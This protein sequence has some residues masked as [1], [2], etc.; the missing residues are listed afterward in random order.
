METKIKGRPL[1]STFGDNSESNTSLIMESNTPLIKFELQ[2]Q[3]E[4]IG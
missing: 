2:K 3:I 4:L 1:F